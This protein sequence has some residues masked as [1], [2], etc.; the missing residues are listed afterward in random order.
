MRYECRGPI[1]RGDQR[2]IRHQHE[3]FWREHASELSDDTA[4]P[5]RACKWM[6]N[7]SIVRFTMEWMAVAVKRKRSPAI[8]WRD[9]TFSYFLITNSCSPVKRRLPIEPLVIIDYSPSF[10]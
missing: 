5:Q 6:R 7:K 4:M 10:N 8:V 3:T 2:G 1:G 9:E